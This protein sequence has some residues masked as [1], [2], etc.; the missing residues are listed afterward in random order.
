MIAAA[1][2]AFA[3]AAQG[4]PE[5]P[6]DET[7]TTAIVA[8]DQAALR[9]SP[10]DAAESQVSL[11]LGDALEIRGRAKD[12]LKVYDHRRERAGYVRASQVRVLMLTP[13]HAPELLAVAEFLR[14]MPGYESLGIGYVAAYIA[15]APADAI[16][17]EPFDAL[18]TMAE[19]L[20]R[21]ASTNTTKSRAPM[22]TAQLEAVAAYGVVVKSFERDDRMQLCYDGEAFR[23]VLALPADAEAKARAA[24]ALT[25]EDCIDPAM[26]PTE[27]M[28]LD[29]WRADVLD[30]VPRTDLPAH[31]RHRVR[32][33]SAA[34][35]ASLAFERARRGE[36]AGDA[37]ERALAELAGVDRHELADGDLAAYDE[38]AV[39]VG[40][41]RWASTPMR[42]TPTT[43]LAITT[44]P[45]QPGETCVTLVD[46]V[47]GKSTTLAKRCTFG[48]VWAASQSAN[49][50]GTAVALAV[51]PLAGW[52]EL[53]V[54][55]REGDG[56]RID[57][58][59][60][61]V[62][63]SLGYIEFAG[64]VPGGKKMLAAREVQSGERIVK[65]FEVVDIAT[66]VVDRHADAPASLS[67]FYRWQDAA[68]K[69]ET[70]ALR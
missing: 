1:L 29:V 53:W 3:L 15:A 44:S 48:I 50:S 28:A 57:T 5:T 33:R 68:W 56:W 58:A 14:D 17:A 42:P 35:W 45:G 37:G 16:G 6:A 64:W 47:R 2:F 31:V 39:R 24:L 20:A 60:P 59:P 19:R 18:G 61:G 54:F 65:R 11:A 32:L 41:S 26:T 12:Y 13:A 30:R 10:R 52:R 55:H 21:R 43:G 69:R 40:A 7:K 34:V 36:D 4:A 70:I 66:L 9:A 38:A 27:R 62:D 23:R 67:L 8:Q 49:A 63:G 46:R 22:I 25:R 51:Q